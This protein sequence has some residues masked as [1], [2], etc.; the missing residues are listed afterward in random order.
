MTQ[1]LCRRR[2]LKATVTASLA[3]TIPGAIEPVRAVADAY[4][5]RGLAERQRGEQEKAIASF[6]A[7]I[8][9]DPEHQ[10][11][12]FHRGNTL[13]ALS[14]VAEAL[15]DLSK[16]IRLDPTDE[17][18]LHARSIAFDSL[19]Y[20]EQAIIDSTAILRLNPS[21]INFFLRGVLAMGHDPHLAIADFSER[22]RL[23][24][25]HPDAFCVRAIV[26]EEMS[27][28]DLALDDYRAAQALDPEDAESLAE[29]IQR[30]ERFQ[31]KGWMWAGL[32]P[33][34]TFTAAVP[35]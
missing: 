30:V 4:L 27:R 22:I 2:F 13:L 5:Q 32:S 12:H 1:R 29:D 24:P 7:A 34:E 10:P 18:A 25:K 16:A 11:A 20:S 8:D 23:E 15:V 19:G 9:I 17:E 28:L 35:P 26:H 31:Q 14:R 21:P 6:G 3:W 33:L